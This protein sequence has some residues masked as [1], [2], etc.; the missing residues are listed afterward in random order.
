VTDAEIGEGAAPAVLAVDDYP[1][2]LLALSAILESLPIRLVTA[3]SGRAAIARAQEQEFGV[4]L[5]DV[6][7]PEMDGFE[8]LTR[9]RSIPACHETPVILLTAYELAPD[10]VA[11]LEGMGMVDYILKP[12]APV[13]L[14]SKIS[15]LMSLHQRGEALAAKDR[16]IAMLAHDLQGPL[17]A[18]GFSADRLAHGNLDAGLRPAADRIRRG[19]GR[20]TEMIQNLT[21]HARAG[22][23]AFPVASERMDVGELCREI[24]DEF[25]EREPGR[26]D[27]GAAGDLVGEWD[28]NRLYQ[29]IANLLTNALRYG[30]GKAVLRARQADGTVEVSVHNDGPPIPEDLLR[31]IFKPFERG[32]DSR[33]G[34]GL[35]LYIVHEIVKAHHGTVEVTSTATDGTTFVVRLPRRR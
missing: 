24:S 16:H 32:A 31:T 2:N 3:G 25:R 22:R 11:Q 5:L 35:G 33:S 18:I 27:F 30:E 34:L 20:M 4:I 29:A 19:V 7:M 12:I 10:A 21:D 9:L 14:K 15:A 26:V 1:V 17:M 6:M 28:R 8:T 23:G 13:I